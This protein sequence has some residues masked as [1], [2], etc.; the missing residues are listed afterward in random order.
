MIVDEVIIPVRLLIDSF[1]QYQSLGLMDRD[2]IDSF[3]SD[4]LYLDILCIVRSA[5]AVLKRDGAQ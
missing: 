3:I 1:D 2:T 4:S 5:L